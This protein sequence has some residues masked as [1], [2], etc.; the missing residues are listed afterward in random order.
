MF[1]VHDVAYCI[2]G[3]KTIDICKSTLDSAVQRTSSGTIKPIDLVLTD[4]RMP[5]KSGIDVIAEV[6]KY[7]DEIAALHPSVKIQYPRFT[8]NTAFKSGE[9][10]Q[11]MVRHEIKEEDCFDKPIPLGKLQEILESL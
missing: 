6:R 9:L 11:L 5:H 2:D 1:E 3:Q 8:I 7:Y 10:E 4:Y